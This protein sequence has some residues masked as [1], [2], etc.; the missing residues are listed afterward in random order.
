MIC[1]DCV[2][3]VCMTI[4]IEIFPSPCQCE[5]CIYAY[6]ANSV[7]LDQRAPAGPL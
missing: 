7:D 2:E 3:C 6:F 1:S 5:T 4:V